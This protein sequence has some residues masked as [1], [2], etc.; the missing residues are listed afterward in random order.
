MVDGEGV[1]E[2]IVGVDEGAGVK[3]ATIGVFVATMRGD[4]VFVGT[5]VGTGVLVGEGVGAV[6]GTV[7]GVDDGGSCVAV[8]VAVEGIVVGIAV[9]WGIWVETIVAFD[10]A[11]AMV[12]TIGEGNIGGVADG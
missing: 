9:G 8:A 7:V 1:G 3:V 11:A 10:V 6:V 5:A 4:R 2:L 12:T